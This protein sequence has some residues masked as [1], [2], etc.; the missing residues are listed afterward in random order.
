MTAGLS[1]KY[2]TKAA[3]DSFFAMDVARSAPGAPRQKVYVER[4]VRIGSRSSVMLYRSPEMRACE[5]R[6]KCPVKSLN[7]SKCPIGAIRTSSSRRCGLISEL[8]R[9]YR[10]IDNKEVPP[11][12]AT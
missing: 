2:C 5:G 8:A 9:L 7:G 12:F 4:I 3:N 10:Q 6:L 1:S 11:V